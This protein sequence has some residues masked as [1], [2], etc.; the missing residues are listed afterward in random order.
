MNELQNN[1]IEFIIQAGVLTFGNFVTKSGRETPYFINTGKLNSGGKIYSVGKFY[2]DHIITK[3][4]TPPTLIFGPAYKGIPL[5]IATSS[6]Y[7]RIAGQDVFYS[8]DRK[9][10]KDHGDKG[11]YVGKNPSS[12]DKLVLVEDVITAGTTLKSIIPKLKLINNLEILGVVIAVDRCEIGTGTQSAVKQLE[13]ELKIKITP[14]VT[15]FDIISF[16][17]TDAKNNS[18]IESIEKYLKEYGTQ[19]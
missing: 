6:A 19:N 3:F 2:A 5:A 11:G 1:F 4:D 18:R 17:K 10:E 13:D 16:L 15:I 8:F 14:I 12:G 7:C 9:E